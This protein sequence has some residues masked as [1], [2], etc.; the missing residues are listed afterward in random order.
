MLLLSE[1]P[2]EWA[3]GLYQ[4]PSVSLDQRGLTTIEGGSLNLQYVVQSTF[5]F[6]F[7]SN[8]L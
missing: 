7:L 4:C 1:G 5:I 3:V 2:E 6:Y 8:R